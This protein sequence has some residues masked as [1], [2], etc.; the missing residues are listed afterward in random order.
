MR[1]HLQPFG[2]CALVV[3]VGVKRRCRHAYRH[4]SHD[5]RHDARSVAPARVDGCR[6]CYAAMTL[7][8]PPKPFCGSST[9][10]TKSQ[11]S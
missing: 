9:A 8:N 4:N 11:N 5:H 2:P 3:A 10:L 7:T 1:G 6:S